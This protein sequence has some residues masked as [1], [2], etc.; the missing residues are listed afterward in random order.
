M[1]TT[2]TN[3]TW[4]DNPEVK[5]GDYGEALFKNYLEQLG[6]VIYQPVTNGSHGF[7][8][9]AYKN[10]KYFAVEVKT[11]PMCRKYPETG[12]AKYLYERYHKLSAEN[13][14]PLLV[15]FVDED[16]RAIYGNWLHELAEPKYI[17]EL[18]AKGHYPKFMPH[19]GGGELTVYFHKPSMKH[20]KS[21]TD[22]QVSK[23]KSLNNGD[24]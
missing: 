12:F 18:G 4:H 3:S 8:M 5:K 17:E 15:A 7:D 9:L 2:P 1:A 21:L 6:N 14:M 22:E 13:N 10:E 20:F 23:L 16:K 19:T 11:K 24:D